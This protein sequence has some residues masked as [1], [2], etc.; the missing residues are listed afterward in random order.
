MTLNRLLRACLTV[1]AATC[2]VSAV[3]WKP[4]A[5]EAPIL[6]TTQADSGEG[7]LRWA[8]DQAA[9]QPG[10]STIV[11]TAPGE[12]GLET[13]LLYQ[14]SDPIAIIGQGQV[15]R[16]GIN[17]T[18]LSVPSGADLSASGLE[19]RGPGGFDIE[20]RGDLE[21]PAGKGLFIGVPGDRTGT[22]SVRLDN[23]VVAGVAG[24]GVHVSDCDLADECGGGE[25]GSGGGSA[26]SVAV[27]A[28]GLTVEAVGY[29]RFDADGL[30]VDERGAGDIRL[31]LTDSRFQTVGADGVELD[32][33]QAGDIVATILRTRFLDNGGYCDPDL[34]EPFLPNPAEAVFEDGAMTEADIPG[35]VSGSPDDRCIE[36]EVTLHGSGSVSGY[37]FAL[38]LDDGIDFDEAGPGDLLAVMADSRIAGNLDEGVDFD[39]LDLGR[40]DVVFLNVEAS[41]NTDD[42]FKLSESG[43]GSVSAL[44]QGAIALANGGKGAVI[45]EEDAGD[46]SVTVIDSRTNDNDD[47]DGTGLELVQSDGGTGRLIVRGSDIADG[48]TLE[49]VETAQE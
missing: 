30:R 43:V 17:E 49:G 37:E 26:A 22:V 25:G 13:G 31:A 12:I 48:M 41:G 45:E 33:G 7:S 9:A 16:L 28:T 20:T 5:A 36:R 34:L 8:L 15:V 10:R 47:G 44:M 2:L 21:G 1:G 23:I 29:G 32:E 4:A 18:I 6:V 24:H 14:G 11:V 19:F 3:A 40:A 27:T 35:P 38:D 46:L 39:E 42:G